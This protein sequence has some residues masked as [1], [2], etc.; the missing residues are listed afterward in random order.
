MVEYPQ[1]DGKSRLFTYHAP[2]TIYAYV[3][4]IS[5]ARGISRNK[6]ITEIITE[7]E[8]AAAKREA[9]KARK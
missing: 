6:A 8:E 5:K 2:N 9:R 1:P 7:H 4:E 3:L